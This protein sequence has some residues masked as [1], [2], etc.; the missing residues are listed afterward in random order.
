MFVDQHVEAAGSS[1]I[2]LYNGKIEWENVKYSVSEGCV[3]QI[4]H[5]EMGEETKTQEALVEVQQFF[6]EMSHIVIRI[7]VQRSLFCNA[8]E[9][10]GEQLVRIS[11][12]LQKRYQINVQGLLVLLEDVKREE[13]FAEDTGVSLETKK[14]HLYGATCALAAL[15]ERMITDYIL[16]RDPLSNPPRI[17][18]D[19]LKFPATGKF[20]LPVQVCYQFFL[21]LTY[22]Y[23]M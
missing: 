14:T 1:G 4:L 23:F 13:S 15:I 18:K 5:F 20:L 7:G 11:S 19:L 3:D 17:L 12:M 10:T 8:T 9:Q 16:T 6:S 21:K 2:V 22:T